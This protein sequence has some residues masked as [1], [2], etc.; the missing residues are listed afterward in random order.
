MIRRTT[1]QL[2]VGM[3][4]N[5]NDD[6]IVDIQTIRDRNN[7]TV[8][9]IPFDNWLPRTDAPQTTSHKYYIIYYDSIYA[10]NRDL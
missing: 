1:K 3:G 9:G 8:E 2:D 10:I 7:N 5:N 4:K 6:T